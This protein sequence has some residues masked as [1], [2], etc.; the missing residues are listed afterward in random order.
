MTVDY[1]VSANGGRGRRGEICELTRDSLLRMTFVAHNTAVTFD[2]MITL[3]YPKDYPSDGKAVKY[4]LKRFIRWARQYGMNTY[5]WFMEFQRRGAPHFHIF[6][7]GTKLHR[8]KKEV[9]KKWFEI[10]GSGDV[11]HLRAGTRVERL[12]RPDAAGR[13]AAKYASKPYQKKIPDGYRNV[14]RWWGHSKDVKPVPIQTIEIESWDELIELTNGWS[15]QD[16]LR[17]KRPIKTLFN[18]T[19]E[20][21]AADCGERVSHNPPEARH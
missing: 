1:V 15:R 5:F 13:Y 10:V 4:H 12:R 3:T 9:S 17:E 16:A 18:A 11:K 20:I 6:T 19:V 2:T 14:G 8:M 21:K 7:R